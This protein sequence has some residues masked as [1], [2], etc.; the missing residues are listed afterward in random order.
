MYPKSKIVKLLHNVN[1][2]FVE[3]AK[4]GAGYKSQINA[5]YTPQQ[6]TALGHLQ[7]S[8]LE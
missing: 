3:G 5:I 1:T 7:V 2:L 8:S 4:L 6:L